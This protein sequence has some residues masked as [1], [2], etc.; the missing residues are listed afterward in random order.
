MST[1][2]LIIDIQNDYFP[3]GSNPL[4]GSLEA[5]KNARKVL[6]AFRQKG[7]PIIHIQ[8]LSLRPT[9]TFFLPGTVGSEI[10]EHVKPLSDEVVIIKH[11]PNGFF[12]T[13]LLAQLERLNVRKLVI[14]GMMTHMC[15]DSTT[16]AA[17]DYGFECTVIGDAC[18]S[19]DLEI[20]GYKVPARDVHSGFLAALNYYY[21][22][23]IST[24]V[25]VK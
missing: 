10:H 19:K 4:V 15:V 18:A 9:S 24:E 25:F 21:S 16:R 2:L 3:N 12:Q 8:H 20:N 13:D 6:D 17:K 11:T 23:V 5:S 22:S 1:A 14:C 7:W